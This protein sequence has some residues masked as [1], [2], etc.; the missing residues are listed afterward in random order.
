MRV[1]MWVGV[2]LLS[3]AATGCKDDDAAGSCD[4]SALMAELATASAGDT[5]QVGECTLTGSFTVPSGVTLAGGAG[6]VLRADEGVVVK[7][8]PSPDPAAPTTLSSLAIE[9]DGRVGVLSRGAGNVVVRGVTMTASRGYGI[10]IESATSAVLEDVTLAGPVT[11]DNAAD[12][13]FLTAD[14]ETM[15]TFGL[16]L[17]AAEMVEM[18]RVEVNGFAEFGV[19]VLDQTADGMPAGAR[20]SVVWSGGGAKETLGTGLYVAGSDAAI[21][22][23][24]IMSTFRGL[25]GTPAYGAVFTDESAVTSVRLVVC[26]NDGFGLL[27]EGGTAHHTDLSLTDNGEGGLAAGSAMSL[28]LDGGDSVMS[29]NAG[30][31]VL[32]RDSSNVALRDLL[33]ERAVRSPTSLGRDLELGD[34]IQ[35]LGSYDAVLENLV[36]RDNERVAL[37]VDIGP[38]MGAGITFTNVMVH[39]YMAELGAVGGTVDA[40]TMEL[41]PV[42]PDGVWDA[43][44]M[45]DSSALSADM[46]FLSRLAIA[47]IVTPSMIA[48]PA[49]LTG[50]VT[51]SM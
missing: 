21:E 11:A 49:G 30:F 4:A 25:R 18:A 15:A 24:D 41:V 42:E 12:D 33:V 17:L 9:A 20:P 27:H 22:N 37:T 35:L 47:G 7:L 34:G 1:A 3:I 19:A 8:E 6:S 36:I 28:E 13:A 2:V 16:I 48:R 50:I 29:G 10:A 51:P 39:S 14:P 43:G 23:V 26:D 32:I 31:N 40:A 44:I 46:S 45:R 38:D 5:V